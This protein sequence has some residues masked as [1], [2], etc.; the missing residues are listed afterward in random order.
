MSSGVPGRSRP[1]REACSGNGGGPGRS[2]SPPSPRPG[3]PAPGPL[4][5]AAR[6]ISRRGVFLGSGRGGAGRQRPRAALGPEERK[7]VASGAAAPDPGPSARR[8]VAGRPGLF[9]RRHKT[10]EGRNLLCS[11]KER[12]LAPHRR[13]GAGRPV[14]PHP[15]PSHPRPC[16]GTQILTRE[17][18][19]ERRGARLPPSRASPA[20]PALLLRPGSL[21]LPEVLAAGPRSPPRFAGE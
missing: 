17:G 14:P 12:L 9:S 10:G 1:T 7:A 13:G 5:T 2:P 4:A 6:G 15:T 21:R 18:E 3:G 16:Q 19:G 20:P 8:A 11:G